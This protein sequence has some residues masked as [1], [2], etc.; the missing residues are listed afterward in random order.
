MKVDGWDIAT[1][2]GGISLSAGVWLVAGLG[3]ALIA[4]GA[5]ILSIAVVLPVLAPR[6]S[7]K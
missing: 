5:L 2:L 1:G 6:R 7:D 4:F 3:W